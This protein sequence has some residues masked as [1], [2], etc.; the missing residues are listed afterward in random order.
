M[1]VQE[2]LNTESQVP[3]YVSTW[4]ERYTA[5]GRTT[6][7][8]ANNGDQIKKLLKYMDGLPVTLNVPARPYEA[9][10]Q[11]YIGPANEFVYFTGQDKRAFVLLNVR[12]K[13]RMVIRG[14]PDALETLPKLLQRGYGN[15]ELAHRL[16]VTPMYITRAATRENVRIFN[17]VKLNDKLGR[18]LTEARKGVK[19]WDKTHGKKLDIS[20]E[21]VIDKE[22]PV[23]AKRK[24]QD[25]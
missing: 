16:H 4:I 1:K 21:D 23:I 3:L 25:F 2:L 5:N 15:V 13:E 14:V 8:T 10:W 11:Q 22:T 7:Y 19:K 6:A 18:L 20:L 9:W 12:P 17:Q 24:E